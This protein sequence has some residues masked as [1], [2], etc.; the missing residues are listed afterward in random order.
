MFLLVVCMGMIIFMLLVVI[1][2]VV[3]IRS[4][5]GFISWFVIVIVV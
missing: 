3:L 5:I 2:F 4:W 1:L